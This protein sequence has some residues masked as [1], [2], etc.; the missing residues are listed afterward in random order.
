MQSFTKIFDDLKKKLK[1]PSYSLSSASIEGQL[2]ENIINNLD[3][4]KNVLGI[5]L[6]TVPRGPSMANMFVPIT[7]LQNDA[8]VVKDI[9]IRAAC[10][11]SGCVLP[12]LYSLATNVCLVKT[13][14]PLCSKDD[15]RFLK[16]RLY[17]LSFSLLNIGLRTNSASRYSVA[18]QASARLVMLASVNFTAALRASGNISVSFKKTETGDLVYSAIDIVG[19]LH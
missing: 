4:S 16:D 1:D 11:Q 6:N 5:S 10:I 13:T 8:T 17:G 19:T 14:A 7:Q 3:S 9:V 18:L 15:V 12:E 2:S